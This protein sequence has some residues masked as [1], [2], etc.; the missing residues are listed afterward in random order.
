MLHAAALLQRHLDELV[1]IVRSYHEQATLVTTL[2][3]QVAHTETNATSRI[4][5]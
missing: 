2:I 4:F 3:P 5:H 1:M